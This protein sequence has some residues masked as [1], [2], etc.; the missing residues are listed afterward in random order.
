M[1]YPFIP[2]VTHLVVPRTCSLMW[3]ENLSMYIFTTNLIPDVLDYFRY[4]ELYLPLNLP[5]V[6]EGTRHNLILTW[7]VS[8]LEHK[9]YL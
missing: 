3:L 5:Y 8:F 2:R 7:P 1:P 9:L 6:L 4:N